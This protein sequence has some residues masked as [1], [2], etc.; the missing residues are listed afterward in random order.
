MLYVHYAM[1]P[2]LI[3]HICDILH[4]LYLMLVCY[5]YNTR[6]IHYVMSNI[7]YPTFV[8]KIHIISVY[9]IHSANYVRLNRLQTIS[10]PRHN[11][12]TRRCIYPLIF[13]ILSRRHSSQII[14][15]FIVYITWKYWKSNELSRKQ[16]IKKIVVIFFEMAFVWKR[17]G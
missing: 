12:L 1:Y 17:T 15:S 6:I 16:E 11:I 7:H 13:I 9:I 5:I 10:T 2:Y 4:I 3:N 14:L 8:V